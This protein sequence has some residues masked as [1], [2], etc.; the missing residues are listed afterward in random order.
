[1]GVHSLRRAD[2]T[3][4]TKQAGFMGRNIRARASVVHRH[5]VD[6]KIAVDRIFQST[7]DEETEEGGPPSLSGEHGCHSS[8]KSPEQQERADSPG[9]SCV[10]MKSDHSMGLPVNF[11][12][13]N[14]SIEKRRVQQERAD[15][16]VPSCVSMKSDHSM[17][18]PVNFKDG[19]LSIEKR[20]VQQERADSPVPSCVSM[21]SDHSMGLPVNIKHRNPSIEKDLS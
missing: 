16:P 7:M 9:P 2:L 6:Q 19:N 17:G 14:L 12:D 15:S 20:R 13:G 18:L 11:K 1:M 8:A 3:I 10:S 21:K 5:S 4:S